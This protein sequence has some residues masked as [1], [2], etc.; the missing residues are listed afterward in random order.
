MKGLK[1]LMHI[2]FNDALEWIF[3]V[4]KVC[5]AYIISGLSIGLLSLGAAV[6]VEYI[7]LEISIWPV[8][9][10]RLLSLASR[11]ITAPVYGIIRDLFIS[12]LKCTEEQVVKLLIV[13]T[14]C[15]VII[16]TSL[17]VIFIYVSGA[18]VCQ[19]VK[20]IKI[21]FFAQ[22]V[23]GWLNGKSID[24]FKKLFHVYKRK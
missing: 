5:S 1:I 8:I 3:R 19:A 11:L 23:T 22:I 2:Y 12:S 6:Y 7:Y 16:G 10:L 4:F 9:I 20:A 24:Y 13:D 15:A 21:V 18:E 17:Y 14:L